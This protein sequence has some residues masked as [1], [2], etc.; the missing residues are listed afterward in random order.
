[1]EGLLRKWKLLA[2]KYKR[3]SA[4]INEKISEILITMSKDDIQKLNLG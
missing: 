4:S 3:D 2:L 1:M